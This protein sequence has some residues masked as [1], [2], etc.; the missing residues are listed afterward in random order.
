MT[1]YGGT[2]AELSLSEAG[3]LGT[4][5]SFDRQKCIHELMVLDGTGE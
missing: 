4:A 2:G 5:S 3:D 1:V